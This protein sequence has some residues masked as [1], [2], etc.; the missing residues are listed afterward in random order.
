MISA[1]QFFYENELRLWERL[2]HNNIIKIFEVF[3][4]GDLSPNEGGHPYIYL[5]MEYAD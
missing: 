2:S 1:L 4:D 3:D 5:L